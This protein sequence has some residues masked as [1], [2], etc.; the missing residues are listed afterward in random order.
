MLSPR[1]FSPRTAGFLTSSY[2]DVPVDAVYGF[3]IVDPYRALVRSP[4]F[5]PQVLFYLSTPS[6]LISSCENHDQFS[7]FDRQVTS[8]DP[9][10][11]L[12]SAVIAEECFSSMKRTALQPSPARVYFPCLLHNFLLLRSSVFF[13][14]KIIDDPISDC[15]PQ[16]SGVAWTTNSL[17]TW[18]TPPFACWNPSY[19]GCPTFQPLRVGANPFCSIFFLNTSPLS[20]Y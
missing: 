18:R 17:I 20:C 15:V 4:P 1:R 12:D 9:L 16:H 10:V 13:S 5:N 19:F 7:T 6:S 3:D 11:C 8:A 14:L 2:L